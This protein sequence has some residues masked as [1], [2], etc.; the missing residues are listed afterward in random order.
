MDRVASYLVHAVASMPLGVRF[1]L[2]EFA[3]SLS[4]RNNVLR[5]YGCSLVALL[6]HLPNLS[7]LTAESDP[8]CGISG[9]AC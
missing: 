7:A 5:R 6:C 4:G 2:V 8:F 1:E 9:L 3:G